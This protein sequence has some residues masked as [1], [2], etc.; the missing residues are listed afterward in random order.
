M[1]QNKPK[2]LIIEDD[3]GLQKQLK[4]S[5]DAYEVVVAGDR[6]AAVSVIYEEI[7]L[8]EEQ[9]EGMPSVEVMGRFPEFRTELEVLLGC[10]RLFKDEVGVVVGSDV[11]Q[12]GKRKQRSERSNYGFR[13]PQTLPHTASGTTRIS[14]AIRRQRRVSAVAV[15]ALE[16]GRVGQCCPGGL[17]GRFGR[18]GFGRRLAH[19]PNPPGPRLAKRLPSPLFVQAGPASSEWP[20]PMPTA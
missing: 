18:I 12:G 13:H 3:P 4:W 1:T 8:R 2:L 14:Q 16:Q 5:L 6:E 9:G 20:Q 17:R 10:H 19:D 15:L 7:C 11:V